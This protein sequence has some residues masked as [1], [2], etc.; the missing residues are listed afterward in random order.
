MSDFD[1]IVVGIGSMGSS[2]VYHLAQ[3]RK[4]VLGIEQFGIPH[5]LGSYHGESR[6]IRLA[7]YEDPSYVP[8]LKRAYELWFSLQNQVME[9]LL[10]TTGSLDIDRIDGSVFKGS[11]ISCLTHNIVHEVLDAKEISSRFPG[12]ELPP[13]YY[14]LYQ[15]DGG[16]LVP[17][18]CVEA[19]KNMAIMMG[20]DVKVREQVTGWE[21]EHGK[22][23]V[24]TDKA[25]YRADNIVFTSGAWTP[26][27]LSD[28]SEILNIERQVVGWFTPEKHNVAKFEEGRYYGFPMT[29][30][31][32]F[33]IGRYHHLGQIV[34]PDFEKSEITLEDELILRSA[35]SNYFPKANGDVITMKSCMF[36]NTSDEHFIID[37]VP[38]YGN[39]FLAAGFS[40]HGFKFSSVV[41]E[42]MADLVIDGKTKYDINMF[43]VDRF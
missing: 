13:D 38:G 27:L 32:G 9:E 30:I 10:C 40:G 5:E 35:V 11:L 16:F 1:A 17:E 22:V 20:A 4:K 29:G 31:P 37:M 39:V 15:P 25:V 7:Y 18:K 26:N 12:Y 19:Y 14:G 33:K 21:S 23:I 36:T 41:G 43:R 42:I 3:R 6:I 24:T 8:L 2:T 28:T 34:D